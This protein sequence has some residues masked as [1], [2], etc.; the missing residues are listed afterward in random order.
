MYRVW[1]INMNGT[2][3]CMTDWQSRT[4]CRRFIVAR[5]GHWPPFAYISK[6]KDEDSFV[7]RHRTV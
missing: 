1:T 5:W 3:A 6:C 4:Q 7:L 2:V